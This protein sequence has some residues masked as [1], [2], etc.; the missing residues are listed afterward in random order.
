MATLFDLYTKPK[1]NT[2]MFLLGSFMVYRGGLYTATD[3][4]SSKVAYIIRERIFAA[5]AI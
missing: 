5:T 2:F 4:K 3:S 1:R